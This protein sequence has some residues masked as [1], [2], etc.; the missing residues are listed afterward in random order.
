M[1]IDKISVR[2]RHA[3]SYASVERRAVSD[4][5]RKHW[6]FG[7]QIGQESRRGRLGK[8]ECGSQL[9]FSTQR[10]KHDEI[11]AGANGRPGRPK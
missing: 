2:A 11:V 5:R 7:N 6:I 4:A 10:L 1:A 8:H 9:P 3:K